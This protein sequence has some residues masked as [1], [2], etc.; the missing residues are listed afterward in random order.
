MCTPSVPLETQ[1]LFAGGNYTLRNRAFHGAFLT[2]AGMRNML[3]ETMCV[4]D[5]RLG[6]LGECLCRNVTELAAQAYSV[7]PEPPAD[8]LTFSDRRDA[9]RACTVLAAYRSCLLRSV[10]RICFVERL[11]RACAA[12]DH[13]K[14]ER[15]GC[16]ACNSLHDQ[17]TTTFV[18]SQEAPECI[19]AQAGAPV[20]ARPFYFNFAG[21]KHP[22]DPKQP[23]AE[24]PLPFDH[25]FGSWLHGRIERNSVVVQIG[26]KHSCLAIFLASSARFRWIITP[27]GRGSD[28]NTP[29]PGWSPFDIEAPMR[30]QFMT[31]AQRAELGDFVVDWLV[32]LDF[33]AALQTNSSRSVADALAAHVPLLERCRFALLIAWAPAERALPPLEST[34][35]EAALIAALQARD[36]LFDFD[37]TR[38]AR[39]SSTLAGQ[40][41]SAMVFLRRQLAARV[42]FPDFLRANISSVR[43]NQQV[44]FGSAWLRVFV[45]RGIA[46]ANN[47]IVISIHSDP[48]FVEWRSSVRETWLTRARRLGMLAVF[49][50]CNPDADV[51]TEAAIYND[52][53]AIEAPYFYH[54]ER[55]VLPL[56]EHVWF[57]LAARH[58][59]DAQWVMKTDHDTVVFPDTL[60]RFLRNQ[61][62][63]DPMRQYVYAGNLFE[64][65]P[66]RDPKH[67]SQVSAEMYPPLQY[68]GFMSGGAGYIESMALVRCL[69]SHTATAAFNYFPR[70]D[71]GMRL[72][73]NEAG[74]APLHIV[75]SG[76]FRYNAPPTVPRDTV[77][78]HYVKKADRL[79]EYWAPQLALLDHE[80]KA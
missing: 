21:R 33:G 60:A 34:A 5:G 52:I 54:A 14:L 56:L 59:I 26:Y 62:E 35:P 70:S 73:I 6:K 18:L 8:K 32:A 66:V 49:I 16:R 15:F 69:T 20:C 30:A 23:A 45:P 50:V 13:A 67:H 25:V 22:C 24:R 17:S 4:P 12:L 74:C 7:C 44:P 80:N 19:V 27:T 28:D 46:W 39:H 41:Q 2:P 31:S 77:T 65:S 61:S 68:P 78:M 40:K 37:L 72:A 10:G 71:V 1:N 76:N 58:A 57:Q 63:Y 53:I 55:S 51:I 47:R 9:Q 38:R 75:S 29:P 64:V 42:V 48:R 3:P 11:D 36:F 79:R 43:W